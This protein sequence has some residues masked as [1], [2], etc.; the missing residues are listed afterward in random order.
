MLRFT[1]TKKC[2]SGSRCRFFSLSDSRDRQ[3]EKSEKLKS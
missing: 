1:S 3:A 2:D